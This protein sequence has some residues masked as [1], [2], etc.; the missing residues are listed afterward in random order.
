MLPLVG[1]MTTGDARHGYAEPGLVLLPLVGAMT[2]RG[3]HRPGQ[4]DDH[5][6]TP[7]RGDDDITSVRTRTVLASLL[8]LVG[9]MTT[10]DMYGPVRQYLELL[11][12]V[13]A[14]TT[15]ARCPGSSPATSCCY[16]S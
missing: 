9:A 12:L 10:P 5:V 2:T 11:P 1:A 16:P 8:P 6:A 4:Q 13:G 15:L 3:H 7:R 14:M